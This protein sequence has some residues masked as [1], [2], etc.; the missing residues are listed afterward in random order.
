MKPSSAV[1]LVLAAARAD[2]RAATERLRALERELLEEA[3]AA[4]ERPRQAR[5]RTALVVS[6]MDKAAAREELLRAGLPVP[7]K[8]G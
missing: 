4:P 3:P 7:R 6:D 2:V 5:R 1:Q 8:A